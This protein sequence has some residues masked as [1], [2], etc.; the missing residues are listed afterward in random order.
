MKPSALSNSN[1]RISR[2]GASHGFVAR[3]GASAQTANVANPK[4]ES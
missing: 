1:F 2:F 3:T 4:V